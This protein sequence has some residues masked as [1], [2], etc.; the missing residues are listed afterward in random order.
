MAYIARKFINIRF[1]KN[2]AFKHRK[3]TGSSSNNT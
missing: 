2:K 1:K 3:Y